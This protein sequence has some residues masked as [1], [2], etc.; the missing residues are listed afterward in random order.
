MVA[1]IRHG[2][3]RQLTDHGVERERGHSG[4]GYALGPGSSVEDLGRNDPRQG[5]ARGGEGEVVQPGH[6]NEPPVCGRVVDLGRELRQQGARDDER[7]HITQIADDQWPAAPEAIDEH[8]TGELTEQSDCRA[9]CLASKGRIS[10]DANLLKDLNGV[11]P[12]G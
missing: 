1:D 2:D 10:L 8:H 12:I 9:D 6:D 4:D 11:V 7:Y 3:G 5:P